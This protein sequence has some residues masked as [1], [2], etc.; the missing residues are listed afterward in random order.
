MADVLESFIVES[1]EYTFFQFVS[2][3]G[4]AGGLFIGF[5]L[6]G[7][8]NSMFCCYKTKRF[9]NDC[10]DSDRSVNMAQNAKENKK[11]EV[12]KNPHNGHTSVGVELRV[13]NGWVKR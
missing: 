5:H 6:V 13:K 2:D 3:T 1:P 10:A 11:G 8:K 9:R 12:S 4:G 7:M